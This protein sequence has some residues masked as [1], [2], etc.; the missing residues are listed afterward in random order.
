MTEPLDFQ[1]I[2]IL[3]VGD[4]MLD[5]YWWGD[6]YRISPEAPVPIIR[7]NRST[8]VAGGA[9]NV[10]ANVSGLGAIP[11]LVGCIGRDVD[12]ESLVGLLEELRIST[13]HLV[14]TGD[15]PTTVKT[16]IIAH[17]QQVARVDQEVADPFSGP[18]ETSLMDAV[19]GKID[20]VEGIIISDYA[21]GVVSEKLAERTITMAKMHGLPVIVDPKGKDYSKYGGA[22]C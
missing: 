14:I 17:S 3:V 2:R 12:G 16:R 7:L 6:V 4:I 21:K 9:A 8:L 15:R 19:L 18:D 10:A 13:E 11:I 5:R 22:R 1:N 20:Q